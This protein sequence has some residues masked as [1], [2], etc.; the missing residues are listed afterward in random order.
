MIYLNGDYLFADNTVELHMFADSM[1]IELSSYSN[2]VEGQA[3]YL[4]DDDEAT[5]CILCGAIEVD[6]SWV[7]DY[8]MDVPHRAVVT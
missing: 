2:K 7:I 4:L 1:G 6:A 5:H 8:F 3:H